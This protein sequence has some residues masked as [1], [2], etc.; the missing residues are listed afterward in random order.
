MNQP[1][2]PLEFETRINR[3]TYL[4]RAGLSIGGFALAGLL[5][6]QLLPGRPR[7]VRRKTAA[8]MI[9]GRA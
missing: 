9:A 5:N 6:P 1:F 2:D 7:S 8:R 3:R 4:A